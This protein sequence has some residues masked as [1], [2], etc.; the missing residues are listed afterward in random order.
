MRT[1]NSGEPQSSDDRWLEPIN[2]PAGALD[3]TEYPFNDYG[4]SQRVI[5]LHGAKMRYCHA[6]RKWLI[7]DGRRWAID[8]ADQSRKLATLSMLEFFQQAVEANNGAA[9]KFAT[10]S[11]D[12]K[13]ITNM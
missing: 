3:L 11:L 9:Q 2:P 6:F 5:A 10:Q 1:V 8:D 7:Y 12:A 4:N 13:R